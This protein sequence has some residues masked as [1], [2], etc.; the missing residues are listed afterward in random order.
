[1]A[2]QSI[3]DAH[4]AGRRGSP[5][6]P[7]RMHATSRGATIDATDLLAAVWAHR[8]SAVLTTLLLLPLF[9]VVIILLPNRYDSYGQ[10]FVRLG[11]GTVSM[12]A[13]A[14]LSPTVS[15]QDSRASQV[16]SVQEMLQS[17]AVAQ[18]V[19]R[20]VGA[21]R[22]LKP[23]SRAERWWVAARK[24]LPTSSPESVGGLTAAEVEQQIR[25]ELAIA[26][27]QKMFHLS[28]PKD[29]YTIDLEVRSGDPF[30]SRDLLDS[31][32]EVYQSHHAMAHRAEGSAEFFAEQSDRARTRALAAKEA[33]RT[34]KT[35]R[36]IIDVASSQAALRGL[37][38]QVENDLVQTENQLAATRSRIQRLAADVDGSPETIQTEVV[39]GIPKTTGTNM[40]QRLYDLEVEYN[41]LAVK[42]TDENPKLRALKDQLEAATK[43]ALSE[44]GEQ[45]QTREAVNP[46]RQQL[47]LTRLEAISELAGLEA[48]LSS[49]S[50]KKDQLLEQL[51]QL[52][53]DEVEIAQLNWEA[54]LAER[55]YL[56]AAENRDNA[57]LIDRLSS[58]RVSEIAVVQEASLGLKKVKPRRTVLAALLTLLAV[59]IGLFQALVRGLLLDSSHLRRDLASAGTRGTVDVPG[60]VR[61]GEASPPKGVSRSAAGAPGVSETGQETEENVTSEQRV[62]SPA[63]PR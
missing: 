36:G 27:F 62:A 22:I 15:L 45:P 38:S 9:L 46:I 54:D 21:D 49:L 47:D 32:I 34:A 17:R 40:R 63:L 52:N 50:A 6:R 55:E 28:S 30:L 13:T 4:P 57:R 10:I 39:R 60:S 42:S 58:G 33:L 23:Y 7:T 53:Q 2:D 31:L 20:K 18:A 41:E 51:D 3:H 56:R 5:N 26:R 37:I 16:N 11:R 8:R 29:A 1:M 25:E 48:K 43:I 61:P 59:A 19:V 44:R 24:W 14:S 35:Q 12:D